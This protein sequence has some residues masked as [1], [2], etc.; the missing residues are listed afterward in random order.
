M[1]DIEVD[2][3]DFSVVVCLG[4]GSDSELTSLS[5][6]TLSYDADGRT[7]T[8]TCDD[9]ESASAL[10]RASVLMVHTKDKLITYVLGHVPKYV[11]P[12]FAALTY[13]TPIVRA[14]EHLL[15]R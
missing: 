1:S 3:C 10:A 13:T 2:V 14:K 9:Q 6:S 15:V 12:K 11:A 7:L 5:V 4:N 8:A